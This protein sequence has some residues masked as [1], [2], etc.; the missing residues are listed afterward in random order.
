MSPIA[1]GVGVVDGLVRALDRNGTADAAGGKQVGADFGKVLSDV[2]SS[3]SQS[4]AA[5]ERTSVAALTGKASARDVVETLTLA[6]QNLQ[7]ALAV[8]DKVV[9]SLQEINRMAI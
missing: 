8:R 4:I 6:E 7:L 5:A 1:I 9:A 2:A 3:A